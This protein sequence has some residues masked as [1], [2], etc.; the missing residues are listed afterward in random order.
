[1]EEL[2]GLLGQYFDAMSEPVA[3]LGGQVFKF[4]GDSLIVLFRSDEKDLY[5]GAAVE[6][7]M[8]IQQAVREFSEAYA[9]T[10]SGALQIKVGISEGPVYTTTVG[11]EIGGMQPVLAGR[12]LVRAV[13]AEQH[14]QAG[15][16]MV[17]AMLTS[18]LPGRLDIREARGTFRLLVGAREVPVPTP[19]LPLDLS[20]CE[21]E[22]AALLVQ[23][24]SP[25]LA[26][27]V[28][29]RIELAT[30]TEQCSSAARDRTLSCEH[31]SVTTMFVRFDG[32]S[33]GAVDGGGAEPG[34]LESLSRD[35]RILQQY[36]VAMRDCIQRHGGRLNEVDFGQGGTLVA[37]FGAP[38]AQEDVELSAVSC[39]W[40]MRQVL[41]RLLAD[42]GTQAGG[43]DVPDLR[44]CV[45]ITSGTVFVG[46][47]GARVRRTYA[48]VGDGVNLA[49]RL[50]EM[51]GWGEILV[52]EEVRRAAKDHF[53][54]S[55]LG[56]KEIRGK[57]ER[58]PLSL[59]GESRQKGRGDSRLLR[60]RS[61][62][63]PVGRETE[64]AALDDVRERAWHGS[65]QV[66]Q[67]V[68]QTG[69]GKSCLAGQLANRWLVSKGRVF[70]G[71]A[72][73]AES[74]CRQQGHPR[75]PCPY[76]LWMTLVRGALGVQ[77]VDSRDQKRR[78][79]RRELAA[80]TISADSAAFWRE[81]LLADASDL[82][83]LTRDYE[84]LRQ[85]LIDLLVAASASQ[86]LLLVL[87]DLDRGDEPSRELLR[88]LLCDS[89][90]ARGH[91]V[92]ILVCVTGRP[93]G[94]VDLW[95]T[96]RPGVPLAGVLPAGIP[97]GRAGGGCELSFETTRIA[98]EPLS[99]SASHALAR[100]LLQGE[101]LESDV[102]ADVVRR[103]GGNPLFIQEL[104]R[105]LVAAGGSTTGGSA[106]QIEDK[107]SELIQERP[108]P[109]SVPASLP[110]PE[111]VAHAILA[112]LD[113][114]SED[115]NL[116]LRLAAVIGHSFSFR[117]LLAAH[118][119]Q[120]SGK[121]LAR[122]LA[123]L[124]R[125]H[126]VRLCHVGASH[127]EQGAMVAH[128]RELP[129]DPSRSLP[130]V[131]Y[132]FRHPMTQQVLYA[133][134]MR[135]DLERFHQ[136][137]GYAIERVYSAEPEMQYERL[138]GHFSQGDVLVRAV[139][140]SMLAGR[141]AVKMRAVRE[142]L[143]YYDRADSML[144]ALVRTGHTELHLGRARGECAPEMEGKASPGY[145]CA[146]GVQLSLVLERSRVLCRLLEI[147]RAKSDLECAVSL[148]ADLADLGLQ[149]KAL[150]AWAEILMHEALYGEA[151]AVGRRAVQC[152][153][154]LGDSQQKSRAWRLQSRIH[155]MLGQPE[156][157]LRCVERAGGAAYGRYLCSIYLR[158]SAVR[159]DSAARRYVHRRG[160]TDW[161]LTIEEPVWLA[162]V[163]VYTGEWGHALQLARD[164][165]A[166]G[167]AL[168]TPLDVA[169]AKWVLA[170]ILTRIGAF[171][172]ACNHLD[173]AMS[174]YEEAGWKRGQISG[175]VLR[176]QGWLG[177][178]QY[179]Q[180]VDCF[181]SAL[182]YAKETHSVQPIVR[183]QV[184]LGRL[185]AVRGQ[186]S[187]AERWCVEARARARQA[188][189]G[190]AWVEAQAGLA[191]VYLAMERWESARVQAA[192]AFA[193]SQRFGYRDLFVESA[194]ALGLAWLGLGEMDQARACFEGADTAARQLAKTLPT[195]YASV[196]MQR[197]SRV[198]RI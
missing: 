1:M 182:A 168:G 36:V 35:G 157:A 149:G 15:E 21:T 98:L 4:A 179:Q 126:I 123:T 177:M 160:M 17:D 136:A 18:R 91:G 79:V 135:P 80:L 162:L 104:V 133:S 189:L 47:V 54:F 155:A 190:T 96:V 31:R 49:S 76:A 33:L 87:E 94:R 67:I 25:Y 64:M 185:A 192:Q 102:L 20:D 38:A 144:H 148:A 125:M 48:V 166:D 42:L 14:A 132:C 97:I 74:V 106:E 46:D 145:L 174:A 82:S 119:V 71:D 186:W 153:A 12:A 84:R 120:I 23:R 43:L 163:A 175:L 30:R 152:F 60:L 68:G 195:A 164:G 90:F 57:S 93:M 81:L 138:A 105:E 29:E 39:A 3:A 62:R 130:N 139:I 89:R 50:T 115:L 11:D 41:A 142:A 26:P 122:R 184:G 176:G 156:A 16:I 180:A 92:P 83:I 5:L 137:V 22:S 188:R 140:Y 193:L 56:E 161:S 58:V 108:F 150:L 107:H 141:N 75:V 6:C 178:R 113:S 53:D 61:H 109:S 77:A 78:K 86:P 131:Y 8:R 99:A 147:P 165:I 198:G 70:V 169:D 114:L 121:E 191:R 85:A 116:T 103:G 110:V 128:A 69:V 44:Q 2:S 65:P 134:L 171:E 172:E 124:E 101:S 196:F 45:S 111:R 100:Q 55:L 88:H 9:S 24:L 127:P 170:A 117:V 154:A 13:Q 59:L 129:V 10:D 32:V 7:A 159:A 146:Q 27:Q 52:T 73:S 167:W 28:M 183:A 112:Q 118:P 187:R 40:E 194:D 143:T 197:G 66:V 34:E 72:K 151:V 19:A 37:F 63:S 158:P 95:T 51:A 173:E 181:E